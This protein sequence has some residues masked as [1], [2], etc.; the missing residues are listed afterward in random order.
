MSSVGA[1]VAEFKGLTVDAGTKAFN[2]V[3]S[4]IM[5]KELR[6]VVDVMAV[7]P[8]HV[9][10]NMNPNPDNFFALEADTFVRHTLAKVGY[11]RNTYGHWK[12]QMWCHY[13]DRP[14]PE[15][16]FSILNSISRTR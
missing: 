14:V 3:F 4:N 11:D 16:F 5:A 8:S 2:M 7:N 6:G 10:T 12:H 15:K 1:D 13:Y 9:N